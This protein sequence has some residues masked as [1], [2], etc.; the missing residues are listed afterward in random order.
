MP[1]TATYIAAVDTSHNLVA[2]WLRNVCTYSYIHVECDLA[3]PTGK[4]FLKLQ[5]ECAGGCIDR[6]SCMMQTTV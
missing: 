1:F 3:L 5:C 2:Y 4:Y 6:V